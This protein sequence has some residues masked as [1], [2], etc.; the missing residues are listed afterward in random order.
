MGKL[1][2][3]YYEKRSRIRNGVKLN[4]EKYSKLERKAILKAQLS[5]KNV[6]ITKENA[7]ANRQRLLER[8]YSLADT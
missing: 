3:G 7:I 5:N 8:R 4:D 6:S 2:W 1:D